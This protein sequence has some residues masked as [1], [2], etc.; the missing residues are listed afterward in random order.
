MPRY[1]IREDQLR[2]R[3]LVLRCQAGDES[4]FTALYTRYRGPTQRYL[5]GLLAPD[6]A[7]DVFQEVWLTVFRQIRRVTNPG[8][9]RT[10]LF[11]TARHRAIDALRKERRRSRLA[12]EAFSPS[13]P[14]AG[15][16]SEA[17][18]S[19]DTGTLDATLATLSPEHREALQLRFYEDLSYAEIAAITGCPLGTVRSRIHHAKSKLKHALTKEQQTDDS[20]RGSKR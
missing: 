6:A 18:P 5:R 12:R 14:A 9:F 17:G 11:R 4:A 10:W 16:T 1:P 20:N 3:L 2:E 7:E 15:V 19:A 13:G 8:G